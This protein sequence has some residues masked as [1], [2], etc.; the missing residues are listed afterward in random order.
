MFDSGATYSFT[1]SFVSNGLNLPMYAFMPPRAAKI[2]TG[3]L[4]SI[5]LMC[6][7]VKF[8]YEDKEYVVDLIV[9][10]GMNLHIILGI[11]W[12]V[13]HGV[14]IDCCSKKNYFS[15]KNENKDSPYLLVLQM[16]KA[17]NAGDAGYIMLGGLVGVSKEPTS[18]IPILCDF[19]DVFPKEIP[20]FPP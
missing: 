17:L 10:E 5:Y 14:M 18:S 7:E 15:T 19:D 13:R 9:L 20:Q 6:K 8:S 4:V 3:D 12:L 16:I 1:S 2:A 11:D